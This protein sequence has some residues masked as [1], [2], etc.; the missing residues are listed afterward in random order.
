MPYVEVP[1]YFD[2][3]QLL[4]EVRFLHDGHPPSSF[5][6]VFLTYLGIGK[7]LF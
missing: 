3:L 6:P 5:L 2:Q 1:Q 4:L 7:A